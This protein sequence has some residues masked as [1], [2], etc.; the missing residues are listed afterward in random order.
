MARVPIK[1]RQRESEV[2]A[3]R[4]M[5]DDLGW[6]AEVAEG[7]D[8]PDVI[9]TRNSERIGVEVR[10][11]YRD[12]GRGGARSAGDDEELARTCRELVG[13]YYEDSSRPP[14]YVSMTIPRVL[15]SPALRPVRAGQRKADLEALMSEALAALNRLQLAELEI[16]EFAI[17][18]RTGPDATFCAQAL[19]R[20]LLASDP[21]FV[22]RWKVINL[23]LG[24][25]ATLYDDRLQRC[26]DEKGERLGGWRPTVDRA[27][28]LL[29]TSE[30]GGA[31]FVSPTAHPN[32]HSAGFDA[33]LFLGWRRGFVKARVLTG[34]CE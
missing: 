2:R 24:W 6:T 30:L 31:G 8:P 1:E 23:P 3:V 15:R 28:L 16:A 34:S 13:A 9:V 19:P 26:I 27:L 25:H 12:E 20:D 7:G 14:L 32:L 29:T 10:E 4:Q 17:P 11:V 21:E 18:M 5:V 33:V 22:R